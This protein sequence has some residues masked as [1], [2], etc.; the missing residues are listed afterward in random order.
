MASERD[1]QALISDR[2]ARVAVL[3]LGYVGLPLAV[4]FARA[5]HSVVGID[6]D[7]TKIA[8]L[9]RHQSYI[10]DVDSADVTKLSIEGRFTATDS[11]DDLAGADA[12][13]ISVPT[14]MTRMKQPDVRFILAA[15]E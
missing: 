2:T 13:I 12:V 8:R 6:P 10:A 9:R 3:G 1:L 7:A 5:G 14:P 11:Y 15:G 4:S